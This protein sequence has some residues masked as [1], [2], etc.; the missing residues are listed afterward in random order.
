MSR[1][2]PPHRP[3]LST[4]R[5]GNSRNSHRFS[6]RSL[7]GR[8]VPPPNRASRWLVR[9]WPSRR[10][11]RQLCRPYMLRRSACRT[12]SPS[13]PRSRSSDSH[14][15]PRRCPFPAYTNR[16]ATSPWRSAR[17]H[18]H[19]RSHKSD[20]FRCTSSS[21]AL[22]ALNSRLEPGRSRRLRRRCL[23]C[24]HRRPQQRRRTLRHRFPRGRTQALL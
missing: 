22:R 14:P 17:P 16:I 23:T 20:H 18:P 9:A 6:A 19:R 4:S 13:R 1:L 7:A 3:S 11:P 12:R 15:R 24:L 8:L 10:V 5:R 2:A 21:G